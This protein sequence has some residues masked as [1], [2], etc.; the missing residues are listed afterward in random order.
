MR[1][2]QRVLWT[3]PR[4]ITLLYVW[5][6]FG[7]MAS[8]HTWDGDTEA[9]ALPGFPEPA[10]P[11]TRYEDLG[12]IASGGMGD[13]RRVRDHHL[14]RT[15][16]MKVLRWD[17]SHDAGLR[18]RFRAEVLRTA[19]LQHPGIVS[20]YDWGERDDGRLWFTMPE[21]A[22]QTLA[23]LISAAHADPSAGLPRRLIAHFARICETM[24]YAHAR[25]VVH[26]DLKP[27]NLMVGA[28]GEVLVMDF[29]L[30]RRVDAP[31]PL[32]DDSGATELW[33][34]ETRHGQV[35]GTPAYMPPEQ[36]H[37][38]LEQVGPPSDVYA[39]GA[40][41]YEILSG[42]PP[43]GRRGRPALAAVR[44][45]P[46]PLLG[47]R[48]D[49]PWPVPADLAAICARAMAYAL[50]DRYPDASGLAAD[51][52]DWLDGARRRDQAMALVGEAE[53]VADRLDALRSEAAG[54][55]G[56]ADQILSG[57]APHDAVEKKQPAWALQ[58]RAAALEGE[59]ALADSRRLE[60]LH[61]ALRILPELGPA[62]DALAAAYRE[63]VLS[64]EQQHDEGARIRYENL[65]RSYDRGQHRAFLAGEGRL[66]VRTDP[67][68]ATAR[69]L[70]YRP[71]ARRLRAVPV[72]T[73]GQ[74][75]LD[76]V[77]LEQG[78]YLLLLEAPGH[79]PVRYPV[80]IAREGHWRCDRPIWLPPIGALAADEVYVPGGW[81]WS[82]DD[83]VAG[84][85]PRR[86]VWVD[87][88][89]ISRAPITNAEYLRF[90]NAVEADGG[91]T[92]ALVPLLNMGQ[93]NA[94][95]AQNQTVYARD[96]QGRLCLSPEPDVVQNTW[97]PDQPVVLIDWAA[98]QAYCRWRAAQTGQPWRLPDELER[99]KAV[100]GVD[101]RAYPWGNFW[102]PTWAQ[103][104]GCAPEP[105][106]LARVST[107]PEDESPY[108]LR[109]GAG[110]VRDWCGNVWLRSGPPLG[111]SGALLLAEHGPSPAA[112]FRAIRGGAWSSGRDMSHAA[113]RFGA[114]PAHRLGMLGFRAARSI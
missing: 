48:G 76:G 20:V 29:G 88:F 106:A 38:A 69:L 103:V 44:A 104:L 26:R 49:L 23:G 71:E 83:T 89:C 94:G 21:V 34:G 92:T 12:P 73:L 32:P 85:L 46:A 91:D 5:C 4:T 52:R 107:H 98:A 22:G 75:P 84:A 18:A 82:G 66:S 102:D 3:R 81:F 8:D 2:P 96:G 24:A 114:P 41:L 19:D 11:T 61:S 54:L 7:D 86:R 57:L 17:R 59:A 16:A 15:V 113:K 93:G 65:L 70:A 56:A 62:Q 105:A 53:A 79:A 78:S 108:G 14:G 100:R 13:V 9:A 30:A 90:L 28:F 112:T 67:P 37:G 33:S 25:G 95:K 47:T 101:G 109:G 110:N 43:Y 72:R 87:G 39:L 35:L 77:A 1:H 55:R 58:D 42:E 74:T 6:I 31:D 45:G 97:L 27:D 60:T 51:V 99:E 111:D 80:Q 36:A 63:R 40:V 64:A 68:G 10:V 50:T